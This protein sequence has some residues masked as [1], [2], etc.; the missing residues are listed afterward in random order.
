MPPDISAKVAADF[1]ETERR[2]VTE[3]LLLLVEEMGDPELYRITR[4]VLYLSQGRMEHLVHYAD[5]AR[6]DSRNV[7]FWAEYESDI[8]LRDFNEPFPQV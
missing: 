7:I 3:I 5:Q 4:C 1:T 2:E 8:R 6:M